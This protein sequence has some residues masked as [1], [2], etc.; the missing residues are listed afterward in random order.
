MALENGAPGSAWG[1]GEHDAR[2]GG[3]WGGEGREVLGAPAV[4]TL[5]APRALACAFVAPLLTVVLDASAV[6]GGMLAESSAGDLTA[7]AYWQKS[8]L[9]LRLCDVIPATLKT[10]VF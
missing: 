5:A 8:L 3:A 10:I 6:L 2:Q 9:L 1:R 7:Q 4:A